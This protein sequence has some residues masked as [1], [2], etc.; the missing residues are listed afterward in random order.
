MAILSMKKHSAVSKEPSPEADTPSIDGALNE[1]TAALP[2]FSNADID[3]L[4]QLAGGDFSQPLSPSDST[5]GVLLESIRQLMGSTVGKSKALVTELNQQ[6]GTLS[7]YCSEGVAAATKDISSELTDARETRNRLTAVAAAAEQITVNVSAIADNAATTQTGVDTISNTTGELTTAAQEIAKNTE[8]AR[9]ITAK[10]VADTESA[11]SQFDQLKD[12]ADEISKVTNTISEVSDQTKLLA[13]N[14]TIEA[15]RAG[16]AG[17]GFAVVASEVK[18]LASQT[19]LANTDIKNKIDIIQSA[20]NTTLSSMKSLTEVIT[21][22]N[23]VVATI[24]AAAE[25]QSL[26]TETISSTLQ[27]TT[28]EIGT[29]NTNVAESSLAINEMN[30]NLASSVTMATNMIGFMEDMANDNEAMLACATTNF[31]EIVT[32]QSRGEDIAHL[33]NTY[34]LDSKF[35]QVDTSEKGIFRFGPQWSVL[36]DAMDEEHAKIF[37]YCNDI[38]LKV[39]NGAKQEEALPI[40]KDLAD[41]TTHHFSEEERM[42]KAHAYPE[43]DS[44]KMAHTAL[45][46]N[47]AD[48]IHNIE[49]GVQVNMVSVIVFLTEWLKG[50]IL[51]EDIKYGKYFKEQGIEV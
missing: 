34:T 35:E 49:N 36:V 20:V 39:K 33:Y 12:A 46:A 47:V 37:N 23:A 22:V 28:D 25:E 24:A 16:E 26:A 3:L 31:A 13:L 38:H 6:A 43:F 50:H 27:G 41:F 18:E 17:L 30:E 7:N 8:I 42:M 21:E 14:A 4:K 45:L 44:Q 15:A 32:L 1:A 11:A 10:A 9:T 51:G 19:H 5:A 29:M 40:L 48:T 2:A